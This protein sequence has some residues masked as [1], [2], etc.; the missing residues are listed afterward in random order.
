MVFETLAFAGVALFVVCISRSA[1]AE[2][3]QKRDYD[4]PGI[5]QRN[6]EP[7]HA[8]LFPYS[9]RNGALDGTPT[10]SPLFRS[11]D[12]V[13]KFRWAERHPAVFDR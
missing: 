8:T 11:L 12:G 7:G 3:G 1:R 10:A 2:G 6:K 13:W 9:D 5:V 4:D